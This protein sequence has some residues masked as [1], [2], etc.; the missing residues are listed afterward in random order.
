MFGD[1]FAPSLM[2][3]LKNIRD[4]ALGGEVAVTPLKGG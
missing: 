4:L 2:S 1:L 3:C